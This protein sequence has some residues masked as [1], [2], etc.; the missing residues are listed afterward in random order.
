MNAI[1]I[2]QKHLPKD[3]TKSRV[4]GGKASTLDVKKM[5]VQKDPSESESS[6]EFLILLL[7]SSFHMPI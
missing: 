2:N 4:I 6:L 1:L 7:G 5:N 3:E